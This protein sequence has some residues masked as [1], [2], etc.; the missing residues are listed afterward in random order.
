MIIDIVDAVESMAAAAKAQLTYLKTCEMHAGQIDKYVFGGMQ[1]SIV[2]PPFD[3]LEYAA[4]PP[5]PGTDKTTKQQ[6][7]YIDH[8][9]KHVVGDWNVRNTREAAESCL[10]IVRDLIPL[11][12]GQYVTGSDGVTKYGPWSFMSAEPFVMTNELIAYQVIFGLRG[13]AV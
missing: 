11:F 1:G 7:I 3:L 13:V 5:T 6:T 10:K 8:S 4:L 9:I 12:N 2:L